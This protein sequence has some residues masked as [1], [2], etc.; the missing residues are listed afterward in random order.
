MEYFRS[1]NL[2]Q[3]PFSN[4]PDPGLF[5]ESRQHLQALQKLE[6]SIRLKRGLN[7]ITGDVG[8]GKTTLSRQLIQKLSQDPDIRYSL[9]LDPGFS[10]NVDFLSCIYRS[11]ADRPNNDVTEYTLKES[12]KNYLFLKGVDENQTLVLIIDEGQKLPVFCLEILRELLN[13]ETNDQKLLQIVIFAQ[14]EF[15]PVVDTL[16]NFK[17]RI[18]FRYVLSPLGFT[19]T[20]ALINYRL[21]QSLI[22][23][24]TLKFFTFFSY[25]A[26]FYYTRGYPRKI[27]NLCHHIILS[28]IVEDKSC[29]DVLFVRSCAKKVFFSSPK[30]I[31]L[32]PVFIASAILAISISFFNFPDLS[33]LKTIFIEQIKPRTFSDGK[34]QTEPIVSMDTT[35]KTESKQPIVPAQTIDQAAEQAV[36]QFPKYIQTTRDEI[37][38][39]DM[40]D[41]LGRLEVTHNQ[42]LSKMMELIYG[43]FNEGYL[44]KLLNHNAQIKNP[45][46]I[47]S[48]VWVQFPEMDNTIKAVYKDF[49]CILLSQTDNFKKAYA[50]A[51]EYDNKSFNVRIV[52]ESDHKGGHIF[53]IIVNRYFDTMQ[54]AQDFKN[55]DPMMMQA[56]TTRVAAL[57][58]GD[59]PG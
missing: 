6:I 7:V 38:K 9:V 19:E 11:F 44:K 49:F 15:D 36:V 51:K 35:L 59:L 34:K 23:G 47:R 14:K 31:G 48:G 55:T 25:V 50:L 8:T 32:L 45:N 26:L 56:K 46:F 5:Y 42:T 10:S 41:M 24:E 21:N 39:S 28:L 58:S 17:D 20:K 54:E 30:K 53:S 13:Y 33:G 52:H 37:Q 16:E 3:E 40:P 1:F 27:I 57:I 18:N 43:G 12:I 22:P 29:A 4:S 2:D